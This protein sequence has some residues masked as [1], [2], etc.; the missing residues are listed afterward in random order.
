MAETSKYTNILIFIAIGLLIGFISARQGLGLAYVFELAMSI[1]FWTTMLGSIIVYIYFPKT[2]EEA[3]ES[4][5][6]KAIE[7]GK[8]PKEASD[9]AEEH[10]DDYFR[11]IDMD[12]TVILIVFIFAFLFLTFI[13]DIGAVIGYLFGMI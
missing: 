1:S 5:I 6:K 4:F 8:T 12:W 11:I 13:V 10:R 7:E 9:S 3:R 2:W